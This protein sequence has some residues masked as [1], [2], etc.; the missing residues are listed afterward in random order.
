MSHLSITFPTFS[1]LPTTARLQFGIRDRTRGGAKTA[2]QPTRNS[3]SRS[4]GSRPTDPFR[5]PVRASESKPSGLLTRFAR[6]YLPGITD[7]QIQ[8]L[9]RPHYLPRITRVSKKKIGA[10][11]RE[12]REDV[13]TSFRNAL[14]NSEKTPPSATIDVALKAYEQVFYERSL[15]LAEPTR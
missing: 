13:R 6:Q 9:S 10:M 5:Q 2:G 7:A 15:E 8:V 11:P 14:M 1:A 3:T 4:G 12:R